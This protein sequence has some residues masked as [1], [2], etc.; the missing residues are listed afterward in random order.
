M[1]NFFENK[2]FIPK[3]KLQR[4][5]SVS[6]LKPF[7]VNSQI[8]SALQYII[9]AFNSS[10][11]VEVGYTTI[12]KS[13]KLDNPSLK[14][15]SIW[16]TGNS[17]RSHLSNE[18][19]FNYTCVTNATPDEIKMILSKS[20]KDF[21]EIK[22]HG[23]IGNIEKYSNLPE[24]SDNKFVFYVSKIDEQNNEMEI[25]VE[26]NNN[27]IFISTLNKNIKFKIGKNKLREFTA[28]LVEDAKGRD[29]SV[30][31]IYLKLKNSE[32]EN[33]EIFDP[34]G[35][36]HDISH[37]QIKLLHSPEMT[38]KANPSLIITI[39]ELSA[40]YNKDKK[41]NSEL[42]SS[43][44]NLIDDLDD[45]FK[46]FNKTFKNAIN[47]EATPLFSFLNNMYFTKM[48][49]KM[50]P[51]LKITMPH[52]GLPRYYDFIIGY[53]LHEN[54]KTKIVE[55]LEQN[56][57][58]KFE[59]REVLFVVDLTKWTKTESS[60]LLQ[61]ILDHRN[62]QSIS[63]IYNYLKVFGKDLIFKNLAKKYLED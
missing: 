40:R 25:T 50:F 60:E 23:E 32:G 57:F 45:D 16:L 26:V 8:N 62:N 17:L 11:S 12:E 2:D 14:K 29:F 55:V 7:V 48:L 59:I 30:N 53:T 36:M 44:K 1:K 51:D 6:F 34:V 54:E 10:D 13:G 31:A 58:N 43:I 35:G 9:D 22:P 15:K 33:T 21:Q 3:V 56:G 18:T 46:L 27:K 63:K 4:N 38:F 20:E 61:D 42:L 52:I 37:K 47:R 39:C 41:I 24:R 49:D 5:S 28:S 19:F